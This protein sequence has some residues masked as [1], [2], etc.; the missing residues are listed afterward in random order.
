MYCIYT[1]VYIRITPF[2][3]LLCQTFSYAILW[4]K[5][6]YWAKTSQS[7]VRS[8]VGCGWRTC[9]VWRSLVL[10]LPFC[11]KYIRVSAVNQEEAK[12]RNPVTTVRGSTLS[13]S[14]NVD[15]DRRSCSTLVC[16]F[17]GQNNLIFVIFDDFPALSSFSIQPRTTHATAILRLQV[18]SASPQF[19]SCRAQKN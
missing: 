9:S 2:G 8:A 15:R 4:A 17:I 11:V 14:S 7:H 6:V 18:R 16:T 13:K 10:R 5:S 1:C 12:P 3:N 19:I